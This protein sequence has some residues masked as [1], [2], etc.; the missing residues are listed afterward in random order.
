VKKNL[1]ANRQ[2]ATSSSDITSHH[3]ITSH[4]ND[5]QVKIINHTFPLHFTTIGE[6]EQ[7]GKRHHRGKSATKRPQNPILWRQGCFSVRRNTHKERKEKKR[8]RN[9]KC[10]DGWRGFWNGS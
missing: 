4:P 1:P 5:V 10:L 7:T 2:P 3:H 6:K 8:K 9:R